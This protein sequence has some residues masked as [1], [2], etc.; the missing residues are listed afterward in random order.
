MLARSATFAFTLAVLS[1]GCL[2]AQ[3]GKK[4]Q[5]ASVSQVVSNARI[6]IVYRRPVARGRELFGA[7]VPYGKIWT[8]SADSAAVLTTSSDID[9]AGQRLKKGTY[10]VWMIPDS[11][12]WSVVFSSDAHVFHLSRPSAEDEVLRVKVKSQHSSDNMESLGFYFPMVD[13]DSAV[14][15]MQWGKTTVPMAIKAR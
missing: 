11:A 13:A 2:R 5:L 15:V 12:E 4:S 3:P 14:L 1:A 10:A 8:P 6:E 7:L 9:V